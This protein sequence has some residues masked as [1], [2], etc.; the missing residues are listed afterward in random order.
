MRYTKGLPHVTGAL[1]Y[2]S[3][4]YV[5]SSGGILYHSQ[6]GLSRGNPQGRLKDGI[7]D[8]YASPAAGDGKTTVLRARAAWDTLSSRDL[9][10]VVIATSAIAGS[11]I[12]MRTEGTLYCFGTKNLTRESRAEN[13]HH[14]Q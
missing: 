3:V 9:D 5:I 11:R 13:H 8:Y 7:G 2:E 10:E 4:L 14:Q 12:Y 6:S 1:L